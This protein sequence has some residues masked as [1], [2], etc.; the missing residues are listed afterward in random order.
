MTEA[1]A[2]PPQPRILVVTAS[3]REDSH[4]VPLADALIARLTERLSDVSVDR[5]DAFADLQ[6]FDARHA[7]ARWR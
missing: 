1:R 6:P 4:S 2:L 7:A 5:I 3:P